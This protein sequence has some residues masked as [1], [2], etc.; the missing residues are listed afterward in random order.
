MFDNSVGD[1]SWKEMVQEAVGDQKDLH[2]ELVYQIAQY[3]EI[4]EALRWAHFY[5]VDRSNW[6]HNVRMLDENPDQ[7]R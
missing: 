7:N 6:P 4:A 3:G 2:I 1:E 5:N